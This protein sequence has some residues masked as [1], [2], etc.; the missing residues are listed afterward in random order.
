MT[1]DELKQLSETDIE[2]TDYSNLVN[3]ENIGIDFSVPVVKRVLDYMERVKNPYCF[4]C[5]N[6]PV[7][8]RFSEGTADLGQKIVRYFSA[9]KH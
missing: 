9:L 7:K 4:L 6:V 1:L 3:I 2:K 5:G 8:V